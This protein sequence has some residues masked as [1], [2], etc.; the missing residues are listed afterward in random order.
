M[1]S[2]MPLRMRRRI[3]HAPEVLRL[4]RSATDRSAHE[5]CEALDRFCAVEKHIEGHRTIEPRPSS[6]WSALGDVCVSGADEESRLML[7]PS[8]RQVGELRFAPVVRRT[9]VDGYSPFHATIFGRRATVECHR[10]SEFRAA[11]EKVSSALQFIHSA[12]AP[13][14]AMLDA[15]LRVVAVARM[16][17]HLESR[18]SISRSDLRGLA[19]LANL[20]SEKWAAEEVVDALIHEGIHA[21]LGKAALAEELFSTHRTAGV[22]WTV[23]PWSGRRLPLVTFVHASFVWFGL[24]NFWNL[25]SA[26][27]ERGA[28]FA[29]RARTGFGGESFLRNIPPEGLRVLEPD[30]VEG[31][32]SMAAEVNAA[33]PARPV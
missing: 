33:Q 31:I 13:A 19:G 24:W 22:I 9:V 3:E 10:V 27:C 17:E 23:S 32:R 1:L 20:H 25:A 29:A 7:P 28:L 26:H 11:V 30:V 5:V 2:D 16:P 12:C 6:C 4:L 18:L 8:Y 21:L 14:C 15:C